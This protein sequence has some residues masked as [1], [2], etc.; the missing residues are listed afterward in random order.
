MVF[1]LTNQL[2]GILFLST[3]DR[4]TVKGLEGAIGGDESDFPKTKTIGK[5]AD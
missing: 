5:R 2:I 4:N 1:L 3:I